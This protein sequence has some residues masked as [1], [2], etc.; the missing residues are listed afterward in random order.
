MPA[1]I[2]QFGQRIGKPTCTDIM[3]RK[4]G[5]VLTQRPASIDYF[6]TTP[7]HFRVT[8]LYRCEVQVFLAL[9][10]TYRGSGTTAQ[11]DQHGGPTQHNDAGT[12]REG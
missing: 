12:R 9:P 4:D 10:A 7:L 5:I 8:P 2:E 3:D 11:P 1:V 6:L